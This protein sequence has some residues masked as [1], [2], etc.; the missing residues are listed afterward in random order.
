MKKIILG[1]CLFATLV[2]MIP[3]TLANGP[4]NR[5]FQDIKLPTQVVLE[6][7]TWATPKIGSAITALSAGAVTNGSATT[8]TTFAAQ[9][10]YPRNLVMTPGGTTANVGAGTA[11]VTGTNIFGKTITENFTIAS[12]QSTATTGALAFASITSV[13]FPA[14]TG[15]GVTL[16]I[17]AGNKLGTTRCSNDAGDY[18]FS[19]FNGAYETT[20]GTYA[21]GT[22]NVESNTFTPNGT[23]DGTKP[24]HVYFVQNFRCYGN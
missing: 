23:M 17:V 1:L 11:V 20:R 8:F 24:V 7:Y 13:V 14:A 16:T 10:D 21:P 2:F 18:V 15:T 5:F 19:K 6:R 22:A 9:P 4:W 12:T 3:S